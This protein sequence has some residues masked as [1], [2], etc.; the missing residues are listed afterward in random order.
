MIAWAQRRL[1]Q[2]GNIMMQAVIMAGGKGTRLAALTKDEIPKPMVPVAGKP[3][4]LWQVERLKENGI[5]DI[6]MVIGHLGEKIREYFGDGEKFGI[7]IRYFE[8]TEPLGTAGSF[9]Y[10]KDMIHGDRFVMMSGDLFFDIDFQRMIHFHEE[11]GAVATLFVHPNGHPFD[12]DLLVLDKDDKIT[13]FDSKH[14]VRDYWYENCVNAGIFVFEKKICDYV[15]EP[16]KRI[17]SIPEKDQFLIAYPNYVLRETVTYPNGGVSRFYDDGV[18]MVIIDDEICSCRDGEQIFP[19]TLITDKQNHYMKIY[20]RVFRFLGF[21]PETIEKCLQKSRQEVLHFTKKISE[22]GE[23]ADSSPLELLFEQNFTDVYGMR[24]LKYLQKEFRISD[25]DG[26]NYFLDYLIDTAD[27][28]VAIEENG[29]H[30]HHPQLIGIEGYRKQLRKQNTCA[31]WGLKLYRF[32]TEDCRFKDR[33]EDDI[34][35]YLG[36]DTGGFR[37]AGLLLERKT[38]L[39]EH[40]EISLAQIQERREK[41]IRAFLIVLPTAAGKS[42]IVEEDIQKFAAGKEQF[43]ALI[44]APNTNIIADWKERIEND[45]QPLQDQIDIKTYSYAVRHYHEKTRDY[46]SY[47]VVDEAHHAVAPMLKRVIQYYAPEFLVGL[48]ATDQRPDKKRLEEIFGNYTTELSLK[49]AM[50]KGVVARANVYRIETNIDL[51]HVRFNG[52]DYVNADLEKS[53]RVTSRNELIVNVLKDYFTEGDAGKRQGIIFCINK[54]HTKEMARL[55]NTA[56]IS[57]QD[58]SGDTKHPEKVMQEFKEHKIRF[59]CACDMISE[60]WDYPGLGI[61]VMARPTLSKVLYLQ[62]IGRGLRRTS[63]KKN[64][65]VIDVVDEYG[66]MV[67]PCSMHAIFGNSL[68]VPFGDI[69]RQDYLPGQMIEIDGITERVERI[70]EVDIHTFEEKYGDYYSQEQLAREYFVNTGTITSWI[71]KG[72][73]TPAVEFPF[74]SKKISLF[75]PEDVEKYRKELNI[76]EHNDDT[77]RD[78]FFAFLEERDYSLSYK[79]PFL[80]SFIDHMDTIGDA[81][82]EDVLTD[83]IAFYQDRID[84]GL[85]VDR[86][87]CPYNAETLKDR[88]MIKSSMLTNPFEKFERKRFM[89]YSK[90]LG[91]I[92]LNHALLAKMSEGDWERVKGQMKEDLERYYRE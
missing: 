40:Q 9:Y 31:L 56:G 42:R 21:D 48:T 72:K 90:D 49:D 14:N 20:R 41:G 8:E 84:K 18:D 57:A 76:Q 35:S 68:Y 5:T 69:T 70:V 74:G 19:Y 79:M 33:I 77:V 89:Y 88:K 16:V 53:V 82:I 26:N 4:L 87:S 29:I 22:R 27:S 80:L 23:H 71:R 86:P 50:E 45:L 67:R 30:Y 34:R 64:V 12:S 17:E 51:S 62:Q 7:A 60:G 54:A 25:E 32:S 75:S 37:E 81:K 24:A 1:R 59:L 3:L 65:F 6:I 15:P 11:K 78:D 13:A 52:K 2:G 55:L 61:L 38:E 36:K 47:I 91:V 63:I 39:Y 85:P 44:L 58:Y 10:L 92:S 66:A 73:I 46:Y 28:R 43:R 83:Y